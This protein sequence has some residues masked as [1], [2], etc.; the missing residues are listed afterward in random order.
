MEDRRLFERTKVPPMELVVE[1]FSGERGS[2]HKVGIVIE[3]VSEEGI[4]FV[5]DIP[6]EVNELITFELPN[7]ASE[8]ILQG[9]IVWKV[10]LETGSYRFGLQIMN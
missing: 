1:Q 8:S 6:F 3:D 10:E 9:R 2:Y 7:F 4:R 5:A